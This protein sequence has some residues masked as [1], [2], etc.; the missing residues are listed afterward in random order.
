MSLAIKVVICDDCLGELLCTEEL[1]REFAKE[2]I[3]EVFEISRYPMS[4]ELVKD[5]ENGLTADIYILD[6]VMPQKSGIEIGEAI[7][8]VS[9]D[10]IIIFTTSSK[11]FALEAFGVKAD[12]YLIKPL[13]RKELFEALEHSTKF[14]HSNEEGHVPIK[15]S[16]GIVLMG[17]NRI[18][19][20]ECLKRRAVYHLD[21]GKAVESILMRKSFEEELSDL[22]GEDGFVQVHK[23]YIVNMNRIASIIGENITTESGEV[24]RISKRNLGYVKKVYMDYIANK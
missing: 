3:S 2:H 19:F 8:K 17:L 7:R 16:G 13:E 4:L 18:E 21:N 6:M 10:S 5:I 15:T 24:V 20:V 23:S 22:I 9:K 12:R 1:V 11:D 14:I